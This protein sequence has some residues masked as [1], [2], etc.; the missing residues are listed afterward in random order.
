M[1]RLCGFVLGFLAFTASF[2]DSDSL[3]CDL[4]PIVVDDATIA[5]ADSGQAFDQV[6]SGTGPGNFGFLT[7]AGQT[8]ANTLADSLD[9]P[10]NAETYVN[11]DD[12]SD[13]LIN[14][15]DWVEG[16]PGVMNSSSVRDALN[17]LISLG[18]L[19][20]EEIVIVAHD[21]MR[22]EGSDLDYHV[23]D[24]IAIELT[25]Y[26]L[27]GNGWLSF[28]YKGPGYC[29]NIPA[30]PTDLEVEVLEDDAVAVLLEATDVHNDPLTFFIVDAPLN[31]TLSGELP[32]LTYTPSPDFN[33][34]DRFT[35]IANDGGFDSELGTV[36]I[37]VLPVNDAPVAEA[38]SITT[39]ED[40]PVAITLTGSDL[41]GDALGFEI[42]GGPQFGTLSG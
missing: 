34:T 42:V 41:D 36:T 9:M 15:G 32:N 26:E 7:W 35:F 6:P 1:A 4:Y 22:E 24:F 37:T 12:P 13:L 30:E 33:G 14:V 18:D 20:G 31:G 38:Q 11:P 5:D 40:Q 27:N 29:H 2:A 21:A 17:D 3:R 10:G 8:D 16:A 19:L 25:D 23:A 39:P 28:N